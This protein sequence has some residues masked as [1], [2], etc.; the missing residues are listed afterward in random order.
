MMDGR[1]MAFLQKKAREVIQACFATGPTRE[2]L[3]SCAETQ[4][5]FYEAMEASLSE[6]APAAAPIACTSGCA[7]CCYQKVACT[8][9]EAISVALELSKHGETEIQAIGAAARRLHDETSQ[10]DDLGRVR[11]TLPCP[12]IQDKACAVYDARPL[13][14]RSTYSFDRRACERFYFNFAFDVALPHY[15]VMNEAAG[16]MI[17]GFSGGLDAAG[18]DGGLVELSSALAI[19][20]EDPQ[21][22]DRYLAGEHVFEPA[23]LGRFR[24]QKTAVTGAVRDDPSRR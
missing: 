22:I 17:L 10:L 13:A 1:S 20:L 18:L 4:F 3:V 5:R 2:N 6:A 21:I 9:P 23:K 7:A 12:L 11:S 14:C 19:I 16:Q 8:I 24:A 15:D